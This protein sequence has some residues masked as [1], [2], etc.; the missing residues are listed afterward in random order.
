MMRFV[1]LSILLTAPLLANDLYESPLA[2]RYASKEMSQIF[3]EQNK[4][5]TWRKL[6]LVLAEA[7]Q[8]LG[9]AITDEQLDEMRAHLDDINYARAEALEKDL[10]HDVMA[11]VMAWGEQ[12]PK[13]STI[14]H[15]GSTS[16][17]P[18]DNTELIQMRQAMDLIKPK[19]LQVIK[20]LAALAKQY[21]D[22]PCLAQTHFQA[23]Q[24]TTVG[25]RICLWL[26][27]FVRDFEEL[28]RRQN[29]LS[30]LGNKGATGTQASFLT[31][32][33]GDH[34]KVR[35]LESLI[36]EKMGF[37]KLFLVT[38]Q[39]YPRKQDLTIM[40]MLTQLAVSAHKFALDLRVLAHDQEMEE[41]FGKA[42][43]GSSAMP[44]KR[45]PMNSERI[46]ALAR[47][48]RYLE[49]NASDTASCQ[50]LER[51]LDDSAN[52]RIIIPE[53]FLA[54]D[55]ILNTLIKITKDPVV[56]SKTCEKHIQRELPF[57][58][59]ENILMYLVAKK[60]KNRQTM[61]EKIR[62]LAQ[63][64]GNRVKMEA[65]DN[66]LLELILNEPEF[67]LTREELDSIVNI[68]NFT[69]RAPEQVEEYLSEVVNTIE[70]S[71]LVCEPR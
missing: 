15:L 34:E 28:G 68:K 6:W 41:P 22:V 71:G 39:T 52:R 56:Y 70:N 47:Y 46:C 17:Y 64:A 55:G 32:F 7:E 4:F 10:Q 2:K 59:T 12:C 66:N 42:Q 8:E 18:C 9:L 25:K 67:E 57:M 36:G 13:A 61:H 30:F 16:M 62:V 54:T 40:Q 29:E 45:N 5:S 20:Q 24:P 69:G 37:S 51:T 14:I 27:N 19:L 63:Q 53:G 23:A 49:N 48:V 50:I 35:K 33:E 31:L 11:H 1:L 65:E 44:Y 58:A 21:K 26:D 43:I 3:S 38:G 60:G